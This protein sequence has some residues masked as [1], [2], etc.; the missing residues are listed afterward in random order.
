VIR[1]IRPSTSRLPSGCIGASSSVRVAVTGTSNSSPSG[2][3]SYARSGSRSSNPGPKSAGSTLLIVI[4]VSSV[5]APGGKVRVSLPSE[6]AIL[7]PSGPIMVVE[8]PFPS[9]SQ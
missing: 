9:R 1:S 7:P 5:R 2:K 8:T 6:L 3:S 4:T